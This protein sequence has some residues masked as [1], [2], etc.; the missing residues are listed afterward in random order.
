M[1]HALDAPP[2]DRRHPVRAARH[3]A[4]WTQRELAAR[5][6]LALPT[7]AKLERGVHS[8]T[9]PRWSPWLARSVPLQTSFV[10]DM[11]TK[12]RPRA[13]SGAVA[14]YSCGDDSLRLPIVAMENGRAQ[15]LSLRGRLTLATKAR[16]RIK[17][18]AYR[19]VR[20]EPW[21]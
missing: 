8:R 12:N 3:A 14:V 6:N 5:A 16:P 1:I 20:V 13:V 9:Q 10:A 4:G 15:V 2:P 7:V 19:F 17:T 11:P 21:T 18:A